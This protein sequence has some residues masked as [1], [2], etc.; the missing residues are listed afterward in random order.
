MAPEEQPDVGAGRTERV[1]QHTDLN[2]GPRFFNQQIHQ[3]LAHRIVIENIRREVDVVA[4]LAQGE[5]HRFQRQP[6]RLK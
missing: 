1:V 3:T 6:G 5:E 4:C 2:P